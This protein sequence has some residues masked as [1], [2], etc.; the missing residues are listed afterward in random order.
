MSKFS[1]RLQSLV[2]LI[3]LGDFGQIHHQLMTKLT[4]P[5]FGNIRSPYVC[6]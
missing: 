6:F 2:D 3:D 5:E 4:S 1:A